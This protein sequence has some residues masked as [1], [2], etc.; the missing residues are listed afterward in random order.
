[1]ELLD[2][3][4]PVYT[5]LAW[6]TPAAQSRWAL[7]VHNINRVW[8]ALEREL[9]L[10]GHR[11]A[12]QQ[13]MNL[14]E[15]E[16]TL[17]WAERFDLNVGLI[18]VVKPWQGFAHKY[19]EA[20]PQ[21]PSAYRVTVVTRD[22]ALCAAFMLG[23]L[24]NEE[25]GEAFGYPPCCREWFCRVFPKY[26]DPVWHVALNSPRLISYQSNYEI[27]LAQN[28]LSNP[29]LR[30][31]G[32]RLASHIPCSV[33]CEGTEG[34]SQA[35]LQ[36]LGKTFGSNLSE[37]VLTL[38]SMPLEWTGLKGI[39]IVKTPVLQICVG[40]VPCYPKYTVRLTQSDPVLAYPE[41]SADGAVFPYR[42]L[43]NCST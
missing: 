36:L 32:I 41:G 29:F 10:Q 27:T 20:D 34:I 15:Y 13:P 25:Q 6:T 3:Q 4:A 28:P 37:D 38:L 30:Y 9:V 42:V 12:C 23:S 17:K 43:T 35:V 26:A 22:P 14:Q 18:K 7:P 2:I 33:H 19:E 31:S 39:A 8:A 5:R 24:S 11:Q 16:A 21:D 1:M 40:S